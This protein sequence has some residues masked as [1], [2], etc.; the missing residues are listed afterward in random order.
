M[1]KGPWSIVGLK[2]SDDVVGCKVGEVV[3]LKVGDDVVGCIVGGRLKVGDGRFCIGLSESALVAIG[4][5]IESWDVGLDVGSDASICAFFTSPSS[6][7]DPTLIVIATI[8]PTR[9]PMIRINPEV[10]HFWCRL[11]QGSVSTATAL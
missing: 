9:A 6:P 2:V 4:E 10:T 5:L 3:G 11:Y 7:C 1:E 8:I